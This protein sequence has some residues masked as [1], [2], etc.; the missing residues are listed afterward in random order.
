[1]A[2]SVDFSEGTK[3][4]MFTT[5]GVVVAFYTMNYAAKLTDQAINNRYR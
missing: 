1:M 2:V 4:K 3:E 5:S